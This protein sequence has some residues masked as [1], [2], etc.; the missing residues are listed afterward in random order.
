MTI[1]ITPRHSSLL[2]VMVVLQG[3]IKVEAIVDTAASGPVVSTRLAARIGTLCRKNKAN[4]SQ[5]DGNNL[6]GGKRVVNTNFSFLSEITSVSETTSLSTYT[7]ILNY[8]TFQL[9]AEVLNIGRRDMILGLSWLEEN[10]FN[11]DAAGRRIWREEDNY[12]VK[13]RERKIPMIE[14]LKEDE[15]FDVDEVILILDVASRYKDYAKLWS[16]RQANKLPPHTEFDHEITFKDPS[17]RPLN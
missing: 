7:S 6:I 14:V 11:I 3:G 13:C 17:A 12:E 2:T 5:A 15:W 8:R 9:H 10:G 16:S 1:G 4:I